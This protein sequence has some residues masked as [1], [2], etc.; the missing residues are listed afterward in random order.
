MNAKKIKLIEAGMKLFAEKGYHM[1]SVEAIAEGAGVSK[2]AFYL[3]FQSKKDF[4]MTAFQYYHDEINRRIEH[5]EQEDL[6][7]RDSFA[8]QIDVVTTYIYQ[9]KDFLTMHLTQTISIGENT[10]AFIKKINDQNFHWLRR[11]VM[12]I[13]K[14]QMEPY[15]P[16][17]IIQLEGLI[18]SY[19]K[20]IIIDGIQIDGNRLGAYIVRRMDDLIN[21]LVERNETPL[22]TAHTYAAHQDQDAIT[23]ILN[24][25]KTKIA[26]L[27]LSEEKASELKEILE[28]I[29]N[30]A[31]KE[32]PQ[33]AMIQ[34]MLVHFQR[35]PEFRTECQEMARRL[36]ID[37]LD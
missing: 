31:V 20:W 14:E 10:D 36:H 3:Y 23:A 11:N 4:I 30:E 6:Q 15:D 17:I 1:T 35:I 18:N 37:L 27:E 7:A 25:M 13:Y 26:T 33:K 21:G 2:G 9:Y 12:T 34:G 28:I 29:R 5:V 22:V 8:K 19:F 24:T 32:C 16:D